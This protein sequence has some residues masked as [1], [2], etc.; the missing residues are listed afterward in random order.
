VIEADCLETAELLLKSGYNPCALN[1]ANR[2][3]PGGRVLNGAAAQEEDL[4][5]RSN[6]F[7]SLYQ[8]VSYAEEYGIKRNDNQ[9]PLD[10]NTGGVYSGEITVFRG[11]E[12][13]GY[14]LLKNPSGFLS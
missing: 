1:M 8:F 14:C 10:K 12:R 6:L 5:R 4:F 9:Y 3:N 13:N 11:S 7:M 2:Q